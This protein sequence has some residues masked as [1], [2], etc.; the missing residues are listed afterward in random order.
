ME[1]IPLHCDSDSDSSKESDEENCDTTK[2][3]KE[4]PKHSSDTKHHTPKVAVKVNVD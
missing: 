3:A 1:L 4:G 2:Q